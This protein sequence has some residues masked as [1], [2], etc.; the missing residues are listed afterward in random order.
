MNCC[1]MED[2]PS[3]RHYWPFSNIPTKCVCGEE[4]SVEHAMICKREG[5]IMQSVLM[6]KSNLCSKR[7]PMNS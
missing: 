1:P 4:Y 6:S 5:F 3:L 2:A 7:S